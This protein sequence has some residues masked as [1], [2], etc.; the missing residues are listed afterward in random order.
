MYDVP[1]ATV[2]FFAAGV[3]PRPAVGLVTVFAAALTGA[4]AATGF[5]GGIL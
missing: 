5:F 1:G 4:F 3:V 2:P